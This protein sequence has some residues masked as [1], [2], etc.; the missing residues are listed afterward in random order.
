M[1]VDTRKDIGIADREHAMGDGEGEYSLVE[2]YRTR[3]PIG[4]LDSALR[5]MMSAAVLHRHRK[6]K[7]EDSQ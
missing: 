7:G 6:A 4:W 3:L 2:L 5:R 1:T